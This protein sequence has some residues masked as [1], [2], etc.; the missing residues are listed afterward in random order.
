MRMYV[1]VRMCG[2][3]LYLVTIHLQNRFA[4]NQLV[5]SSQF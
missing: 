5:C 1:S 4:E 3:E 2:E